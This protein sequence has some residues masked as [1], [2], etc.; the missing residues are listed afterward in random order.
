METSELIKWKVLKFDVSQLGEIIQFEK[1]LAKHIQC[2]EEVSLVAIPSVKLDADV[3]ECGEISLSF[4]NDKENVL[5]TT[6]GF[7]KDLSN[8]IEQS[9]ILNQQI[10]A[11]SIITGYFRDSMQMRDQYREFMPYSIKVILKYR[12]KS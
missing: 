5:H 9:L 3:M 4:N 2:I 11:N 7:S 8:D 1:K 10:Q 6:I 12:V